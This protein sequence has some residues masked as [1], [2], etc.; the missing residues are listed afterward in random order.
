VFWA[1]V[2]G[3]VIGTALSLAGC[4]DVNYHEGARSAQPPVFQPQAMRNLVNEEGLQ[5][6][7]KVEY[8]QG[9]LLDY[10]GEASTL[11]GL[12]LTVGPIS[13]NVSVESWE[14]SADTD[15]LE[16]DIEARDVAVIVPVRIEQRVG[17]RICRYSVEADRVNIRSQARLSDLYQMPQIEAVGHPSVDWSPTSVSLIGDC[18]PLESGDGQAGDGQDSLDIDQLLVDYLTRA[19]EASG[20]ETIALSPVDTL[21]LIYTPVG[22]SRVSNFENRRGQLLITARSNSEGA[23]SQDGFEIEL[24]MALNSERADCAPPLVADSPAST[25]AGA[26][27]AAELQRAGADMGL[28]LASPLLG[29]LAQTSTLAGFGCRGLEDVSLDGS[30]SN[31][32]VDD[33]NLAD[34][35]LGELPIGAWAEPVLSPGSLPQIEMRPDSSTI[36]LEWDALTVDIYAQLQGVP[37]RILQL[38]AGVTLSLRPVDNADSIELAVDAVAVSEADIESQWV[39]EPPRD[40]DLA[41]WTR[42][43]MLLVLQ[44]TFSL[45]LPMRPGAPLQLVDSQVRSDDLLLLFDIVPFDVD[46]PF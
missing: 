38:T 42:R 44:D 32:A 30:G 17:A 18:A 31:L 7:Y 46:R 5:A 35:G 25:S 20:R 26:V 9:A 14:L 1:V 36:E 19:F 27:P 4:D 22:L 16:I 34:V 29:R 45:P 23:L 10:P 43:V 11:S 12:D 8:A 21:G 39:Y 2:F 37:V 28:T 41:R 15:Q 3:A 40:T 13:R 33:L 6:L 24:D